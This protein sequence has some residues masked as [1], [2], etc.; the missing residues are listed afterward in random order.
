MEKCDSKQSPVYVKAATNFA[1]TLEK[2]GKRRESLALLESLAS[3]ADARIMNNLG[4]LQRRAGDP[5]QA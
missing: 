5:R 1:V 4:I 3:K 2:L